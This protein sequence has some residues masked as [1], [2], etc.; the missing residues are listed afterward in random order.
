MRSLS[1]IDGATTDGQTTINVDENFEGI[2][3][4]DQENNS[5]NATGDRAVA[6]GRDANAA[7]GDGATAIDDSNVNGNVQSNSGDGAVQV[8]GD[9]S[10]P[11]NT[12]T[13]IPSIATPNGQAAFLFLL[14]SAV[15][16]L[17]RLSYFRM[18]WM[19]LPYRSS[20][21]EAATTSCSSRSGWS[22]MARSAVRIRE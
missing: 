12:G 16:P 15:A 20:S 6:A 4:V 14:T 17:I 19:A 8:G 7:T 21:A 13:N 1:S 2:I 11:I 18:V 5:V 9:S 10:A 22:W 3:D